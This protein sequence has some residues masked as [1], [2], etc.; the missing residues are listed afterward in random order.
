MA[1]PDSNDDGFA[2]GTLL[3]NRRFMLGSDPRKRMADISRLH[4]RPDLGDSNT[5]NST[6]STRSQLKKQSRPAKDITTEFTKA[7]ESTLC[8]LVNL[9]VDS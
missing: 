2:E 9:I 3:L 8:T 5:K 7:A 4:I 6:C 1:A